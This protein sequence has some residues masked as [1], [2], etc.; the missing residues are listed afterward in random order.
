M[1]SRLG[2]RTKRPPLWQI[3]QARREADYDWDEWEAAG[4]RLNRGEYESD[5]ARMEDEAIV[6]Q[7]W[8]IIESQQDKHLVTTTPDGDGVSTAAMNL[9][10]AAWAHE[11]KVTLTDADCM[12][13][14]E[15]GRHLKIDTAPG[16]GML[17]VGEIQGQKKIMISYQAMLVIAKRSR[18]FAHRFREMTPEECESKIPLYQPGDV[19]WACEIYEK[20]QMEVF[21]LL[22][23]SGAGVSPTDFALVEYGWWKENAVKP[24]KGGG[25]YETGSPENVPTTWTAA[26]VAKKRALKKA[27]RMLGLDTLAFDGVT[28]S[29]DS[30]PEPAQEPEGWQV[31]EPEGDEGPQQENGRAPF[32]EPDLSAAPD[33]D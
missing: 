17:Y 32:R 4:R 33:D 22:K 3:N 18:T 19:G 27:L 7:G 24:K 14:A 26:D 2:K 10:R 21:K 15:L 6:D 28:L 1:N 25:Y 23:E 13:I 11:D 30:E 31:V 12:A 5:E 20:E 29:S 8:A 16:M 9:V